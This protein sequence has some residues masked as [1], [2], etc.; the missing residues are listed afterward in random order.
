MD[1]QLQDIK[2]FFK[3]I[4]TV[5]LCLIERLGLEEGRAENRRESYKHS[6][7]ARPSRIA[8]D[9]VVIQL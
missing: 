1:V 4:K 7:F 8:T 6:T 2:L 3:K 9:L 5:L